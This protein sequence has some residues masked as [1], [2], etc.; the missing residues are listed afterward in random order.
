M[1]TLTSFADRLCQALLHSL[2]QTLAIV[3]VVSIAARMVQRRAEIAYAVSMAGLVAAV[4]CMPVT[5]TLVSPA[6]TQSGDIDSAVLDRAGETDVLNDG[7]AVP[8]AAISSPQIA[9]EST[10]GDANMVSEDV[11]ALQGNTSADQIANTDTTSAATTGDLHQPEPHSLFSRVAAVVVPWIAVAYAMGVILMFIRLC[12]ATINAGRMVRSASPL[13]DDGV[14]QVVRSITQKWNMRIA[15][16]VAVTQQ[17]VVPQIAGLIRPVILLPASAL[18]G[19]GAEELMLVLAHEIAHL[20]RFDLWAAMVQRFAETVLFFNP[21]MWFLTWRI[22]ELREFCCDELVCQ[23]VASSKQ[24]VRVRYA[25]AL[26]NVVT[27]SA[28]GPETA[29]QVT[30]LAAT[31]RGPSELRRRIARILGEPLRGPVLVSRAG[32][33]AAVFA[34]ILA[35]ASV[36]ISSGT[37]GRAGSAEEQNSDDGSPEVKVPEVK[38]L[39]IGTLDDANPVWWDASGNTLIDGVPFEWSADGQIGGDL[40]RFLRIAISVPSLSDDAE[41]TFQIIGAT[42]D[43]GKTLKATT[44]EL[45][46]SQ[47]NGKVFALRH[48]AKTFAAR[49]GIASGNKWKTVA[50]HHPTLD[51]LFLSSGGEGYAV[52]FGEATSSDN[53]SEVTVSHDCFDA[54]FRI[55]AIDKS[56]LVHDTV[57]R[58]GVSSGKIFQSRALFPQLALADIDRFEFQTR[59][60]SWTELNKLPV[61]PVKNSVASVQRELHLRIHGPDGTPVAN[62]A[63][64]IRN[65]PKIAAADVLAGRRESDGKYGTNLLADENGELRFRRPADA[66]SVSVIVRIPGYSPYCARWS[67]SE[68]TNA[69]PDSFTIELEPAWVVAGR[70][71]DEAGNG[72]AEANVSLSIEFQKPPGDESQ[73]GVGARVKSDAEGYWRYDMI[74]ASK[75]Y[76]YVS[77]DH[78]SYSAN[79]LPLK[80]TDFEAKPETPSKSITLTKGLSV[81]GTVTDDTG[82]PVENAMIRTMHANEIREANTDRNGR[83]TLSGCEPALSRILCAAPGKA[84]ELKDVLIDPA[85]AP[86]DFTMLPGRHV[87]VRVLDEN[88]KG[89]P[90]SRIFFQK[91]RGG[92]IRYGLDFFGV[93]EYTNNEGVWEWNEAPVDEFEADICREGGMQ[94][95]YQPIIAREEEYVFR[96]PR[97]LV[98]SGKVTDKET[99]ELIRNFRCVPG[100]R[101]EPHQK[102]ENWHLEETYEATDGA[103]SIQRG[104]DIDAH[105]VRIEA[106]GYKVAVSRDIESNEGNVELNFELLRAADI[107]INLQTPDGKPAA[108]AEIALG[109]RDEQ[110]MIRNGQFT[111]STYAARLKADASGVLRMPFRDSPFEVYVLHPSGYAQISNQ[112]NAIPELVTLNEWASVKGALHSGSEPAAGADVQLH[113]SGNLTSKLCRVSCY[114]KSQVDPNGEFTIPCVFPGTGRIGREIS[115]MV[116][117]GATEVTSSQQV[118]ATYIAGETTTIEIGRGGR[119][120]T[121][122]LVLPEDYKQAIVWRQLQLSVEPDIPQPIPV[123]L[124]QADPNAVAKWKQ[125]KEA[126]DYEVAMRGFQSRKDELPAFRASVDRDGS[127]RIDN[128]PSGKFV[129]SEWLALRDWKLSMTPQSFEVP[130]INSD[131][132]YEDAVLDLGKIELVPE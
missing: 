126:R 125:T 18:T 16:L 99:G 3:I 2:W 128:V 122:K 121:G 14:I 86:V 131:D 57:V 116:R 83:Y 89:V 37:S 69:I 24:E 127:F 78:P 17:V 67:T 123:G 82:K 49:I 7:T 77:I 102:I 110:I 75:D 31:G 79:R 23:G 130:E 105:M 106:D 129:L 19:L 64:E 48:D 29:S 6:F 40:M 76:V 30:A 100:G 46:S 117:D 72:V 8:S 41:V 33:F 47:L 93:D 15:P 26:L 13:Q 90:R 25:E 1:S 114:S 42:V 111:R 9:A 45:E 43:R 96:P 34:I 103:Y 44:K 32:F 109:L 108:D 70:I 97:L 104:H 115:Y 66:D 107:V 39:A 55:V 112:D 50:Q 10:A 118:T 65:I 120:V 101:N 85:M 62:A 11:A 59:E 71:V 38:V 27:L 54:N 36:A 94:M 132:D 35:G 124:D 95:R 68:G 80:R 53:G 84:R 60:W 92:H 63:C 58:G 113:S 28:S 21:A 22:N 74:P 81:T 51:R 119:P 91:W 88:G 61:E 98:V 5:F 73:L 12:M 20:R 56:G 52:V 4:V 87:R